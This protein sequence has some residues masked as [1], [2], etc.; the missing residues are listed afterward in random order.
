MQGKGRRNRLVVADGVA[1]VTSVQ[2]LR[3]S[4]GTA[5]PGGET[6]LQRCIV[7]RNR[8]ACTTEAP[9]DAVRPGGF[10]LFSA[11]R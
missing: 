6:T 7:G 9:E 8:G 3:D 5:Q 11:D 4:G 10:P 2:V 1:H